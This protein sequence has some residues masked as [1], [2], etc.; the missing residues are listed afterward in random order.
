MK[1][2]TSA[3]WGDLQLWEL[4][5]LLFVVAGRHGL[6]AALVHVRATASRWPAPMESNMQPREHEA[7]TCMIRWHRDAPRFTMVL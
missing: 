6:A 1:L 3:S 4:D 2:M 7:M 5:L